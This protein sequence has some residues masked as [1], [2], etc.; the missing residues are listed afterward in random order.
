MKS[1]INKKK[2]IIKF[3]LLLL[4]LS[5]ILILINNYFYKK[6]TYNYNK[7]ISSIVYLLKEKNIT[8]IE[9]A[10]I[11]N[12]DIEYDLNKYGIDIETESVVLENDILIK[13]EIFVYIITMF[14]FLLILFIIYFLENMK[15]TRKMNE[16][17]D[18]IEEVSNGNY[19]LDFENKSEDELSIL[20]DN[21]YKITLKLKEEANNSLKDKVSIKENLENISHQLKTPLTAIEMHPSE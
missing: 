12:N 4:L 5:F 18:M 1:K 3:I 20:R 7:K 19:T 17:F 6:Y 10:D 14:F 13:K 11:L 16:I 9:I 2:I 8:D 15:K 21:I